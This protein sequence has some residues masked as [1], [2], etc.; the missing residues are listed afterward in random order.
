MAT[1]RKGE[2]PSLQELMEYCN[3]SVR[4]HSLGI[5]LSIDGRQLDE[6]ESEYSSIQ[7]KL[8]HM[9]KLWLDINPCASREMVINALRK[10]VINEQTIADT[11]EKIIDSST[12]IQATSSAPPTEGA[13]P[14]RETT[15]THDELQ[16]TLYVLS[17]CRYINVLC[18]EY[19]R[20][21]TG[22]HTKHYAGI[23]EVTQHC[24]TA[25]A[26]ECYSKGI[27]T[28]NVHSTPSYTAIHNEFTTGLSLQYSIPSIE[29]H[30][31]LY[32]QCLSSIGGPVESAAI[33]LAIDWEQEMK[34]L[35]NVTL[36][37]GRKRESK[38]LHKG[39]GKC[40]CN[41]HIIFIIIYSY[42]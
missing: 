40:V 18:V 31:T 14:V 3:V 22:V 27:I 2:R 35:Y 16:S 24:I 23:H 36:T 33:Q 41:I 38:P 10:K 6:I 19:I 25:V 12:L 5:Q 1:N 17:T 9:Y 7:D 13:T 15:P 28:C 37:I 29:R 8:S 30:C 20:T 11:Y 42:Q 21:L 39:Q 32:I 34:S 4:W 26:N